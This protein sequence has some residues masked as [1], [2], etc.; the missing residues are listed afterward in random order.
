VQN[1]EVEFLKLKALTC[2]NGS[3]HTRRQRHGVKKRKLQT[4]YRRPNMACKC[5]MRMVLGGADGRQWQVVQDA[6]HLLCWYGHILLAC[7][8]SD[9][10]HHPSQ[11]VQMA[12][13]LQQNNTF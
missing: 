2:N 6:L 7:Q 4:R 1:H 12:P 13:R 9:P 5:M 10:I 11:P 8:V 3:I